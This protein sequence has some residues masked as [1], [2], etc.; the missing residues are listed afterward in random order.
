MFLVQKKFSNS[1]IVLVNQTEKSGIK[2]VKAIF[3]FQV[4]KSDK[5]GESNLFQV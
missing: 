2:T 1:A 5:N 4:H 3:Y